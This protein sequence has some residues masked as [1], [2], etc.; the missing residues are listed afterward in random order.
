MEHHAPTANGSTAA[1]ETA[2]DLTAD[3]T[4][5]SPPDGMPRMPPLR[6]TDSEASES[7]H[8][9][10]EMMLRSAWVRRE[11]EIRE[12]MASNVGL[13]PLRQTDSEDSDYSE[14]DGDEGM[15]DLLREVAALQSGPHPRNMPRMPPLRRSASS[16]SDTSL[17]DLASASS[18]GESDSDSD[19]D[20]SL[21]RAISVGVVGDIEREIRRR[22]DDARHRPP[23]SAAF[24]A[25]VENWRREGGI[26][27]PRSPAENEEIMDAMSEL[28]ISVMAA[29]A[30]QCD[31]E[32]GRTLAYGLEVLR[33]V[34]R[35]RQYDNAVRLVPARRPFFASMAYGAPRRRRERADAGRDTSRRRAKMTNRCRRRRRGCGASGAA[36]ATRSSSAAAASTKTRSDSRTRCAS[37]FGRASSSLGST[38]STRS[39]APA[40]R[41]C[42][43][44]WPGIS[45][46]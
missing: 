43:G 2:I 10:D 35:I 37:P 5:L 19:S 13:P 25:G 42:T 44:T 34:R 21:R 12:S 30:R 11:S 9:E 36:A 23:G 22:R 20:A 18:S 17:P 33:D 15:R 3:D 24:W 27:A 31:C 14:V 16:A 4:P 8:S 32:D 28:A 6:Q 46:S 1:T 41:T 45:K 29:S 39:P 38:S 40:P 26:T 7:E